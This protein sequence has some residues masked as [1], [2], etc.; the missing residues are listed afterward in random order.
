M[1]ETTQTPVEDTEVIESHE[2]RRPKHARLHSDHHSPD[3]SGDEG[4]LE[5]LDHHSP[6]APSL[7]GT[8]TPVDDD[9]P[10]SQTGDAG[11]ITPLD[12]HSPIGP[13]LAAAQADSSV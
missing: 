10:L 7:D 11:D 1:S 9:S 3:P 8:K 12:H 5:P 13:P 4:T 2:R 6:I